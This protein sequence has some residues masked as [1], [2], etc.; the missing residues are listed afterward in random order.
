MR[1]LTMVAAAGLLLAPAAGRAAEAC[2][3]YGTSIYFEDTPRQAAAAARK[4]EKLVLILHVS[5]HFEDPNLT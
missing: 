2:G 5:G 3:D 1:Y 4:A